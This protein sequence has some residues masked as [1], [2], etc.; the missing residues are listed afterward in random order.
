VAAVVSGS[1]YVAAAKQAGTVPSRVWRWVQKDVDNP[2]TRQLSEEK[3]QAI[4]NDIAAGML[5]FM[6]IADK[7]GI[8]R[9]TVYRYRDLMNP[10]LVNH[11]TTQ[12]RWHLRCPGCGAKI[13]TRLCLVCKRRG[14]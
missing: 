5:T 4:R 11:A 6:Q 7:H 3:R 1:T 14:K 13:T 12:T 10:E 2:P 8:R 9:E